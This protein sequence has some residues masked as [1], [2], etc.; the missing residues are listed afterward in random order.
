MKKR[1]S[2]LL[3]TQVLIA[4]SL[5]SSISFRLYILSDSIE[6]VLRLLLK[7]II[8]FFFFL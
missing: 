3:L 6:I 4:I 5:I 8:E 1:K 2:L 7:F